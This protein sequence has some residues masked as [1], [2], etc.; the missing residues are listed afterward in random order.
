[1]ALPAEVFIKAQQGDEDAKNTIFEHYHK[2]ALDLAWKYLR[3]YRRADKDD[4]IGMAYEGLTKAYIRFKP[5]LGYEFTTYAGTIIEGEIRR[6]L[7]DEY[8]PCGYRKNDPPEPIIVVS[9][10]ELLPDKDNVKSLKLMDSIEAPD[11]L[12][13]YESLS[14]IY[15]AVGAIKE[16]YREAV[17]RVVVG[18]ET[19][20]AVSKRTGVKQGTLSRE[21]AKFKKKLMRE[22]GYEEVMQKTGTGG[23]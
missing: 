4:L 21:V 8:L 2:F 12:G 17:K 16:K 20:L 5:S 9:L 11:E 15:K 14:V 1:M 7:R 22:L 19:Q 23:E 3:K 18:G 10:D 13:Y 6:R